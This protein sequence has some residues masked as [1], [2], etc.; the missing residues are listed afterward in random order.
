VHGHLSLPFY[1]LLVCI[2]MVIIIIIVITEITSNGKT[3]YT[4]KSACQ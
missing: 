4:L 3:I 2:S 1:E